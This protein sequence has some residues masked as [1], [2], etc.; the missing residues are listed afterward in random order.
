MINALP[1]IAFSQL[2]PHNPSLHQVDPLLADD[3]ISGGIESHRVVV[4]DPIERRR[5]GR[6]LLEKLLGLGGEARCHGWWIV[7]VEMGWNWS[8]G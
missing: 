5:D 3:G 2:I 4:V 6:L 7:P 8:G 1:S